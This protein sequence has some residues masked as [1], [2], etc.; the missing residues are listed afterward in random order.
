MSTFRAHFDG[1]VLIPDEGV[2]LPTGCELEVRAVPVSE[3]DAT[4]RPLKDLAERLEKLPDD[5]DAPTDG[6]AQHDHYLYG[7]PRRP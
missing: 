6:A 7:T 1:R 4:R 2:D 3:S 5:P